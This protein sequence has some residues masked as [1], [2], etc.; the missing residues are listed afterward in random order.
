[1]TFFL[2]KGVLRRALDMG[3][4]GTSTGAHSLV[5][6]PEVMMLALLKTGVWWRDL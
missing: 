5:M 6:F 1:M 4:K 3:T 2:S